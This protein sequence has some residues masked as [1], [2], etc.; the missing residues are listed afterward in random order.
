MRRSSRF[1]GRTAHATRSARQDCFWDADIAALHDTSEGIMTRQEYLIRKQRIADPKQQF[2]MYL[3]PTKGSRFARRACSCGG[4]IA[5]W[6]D[7]RAV[8]DNPKCSTVFNDG[9]NTEGFVQVTYHY[10][11]GRKEAAPPPRKMYDRSNRD[12]YRAA[13]A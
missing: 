1:Q 8:C 13:K 2:S 4:R 6:P 7:G 10:S 5:V 9:G 3:G 11:D 12:F